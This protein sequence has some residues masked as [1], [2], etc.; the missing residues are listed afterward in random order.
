MAIRTMAAAERVYEII[1]MTPD[2]QDP[3]QPAQLTTIKGSISFN[4]VWFKYP[5]SDDWIIRNFSLDI[6]RGENIALAGSTGAGKTT[7]A[8][9]A[10]RFYDTS[11]GVIT[12]DE[13]D[14]RSYRRADIHHTMGIVLQQGYLFSGTILDNLRFRSPDIP[15]NQI[16]DLAG[17]LGTHK[18][19]MALADGYDTIITEGGQSLSLGQRQIISITRALVA[20]PDIL[21]MDEPT[22]SLDI[23]TESIIQKA[24]DRLIHN[25]TSIIIA[26]R[27]STVKHA[28]R[29]IVIDNGTI[30]EAGPHS[31]LMRRHGIYHS[32][33]TTGLREDAD[34]SNICVPSTD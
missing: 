18:S 16:I 31:E 26:H 21:I 9:L 5:A 20:N 11:R 13:H 10:A 1:D 17:Q 19:I 33:I 24:I 28:D 7:I 8:S 12:I 3:A 15:R 27:L 2:V 22:S 6:R 29:I 14:I 32:L 30:A 34:V 23:H 4:H 25:R